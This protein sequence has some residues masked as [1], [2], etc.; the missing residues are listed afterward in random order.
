MRNLTI[1]LLACLY[2]LLAVDVVQ[3]GCGRGHAR[4]EDRRARRAER[5]GCGDG[6]GEA[7]PA[8]QGCASG[9]QCAPGKAGEYPGEG[10]Y[11]VPGQGSKE[12]PKKEAIPAPK[13]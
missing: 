6:G 7:T 1:M 12:M 9:A 8:A 2:S 13:P 5:R 4:R 3:A 11:P 10:R